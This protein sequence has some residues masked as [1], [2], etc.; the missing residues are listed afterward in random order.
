MVVHPLMLNPEMAW[1]QV[2]FVAIGS[3]KGQ[4]LNRLE[5]RLHPISTIVTFP[6]HL[7]SPTF[8]LLLQRMLSSSALI[9]V[10]SSYCSSSQQWVE[11]VGGV[12]LVQESVIF[13]DLPTYIQY[14]CKP[15]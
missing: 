2:M 8:Y 3:L 13:S 5:Q 9:L 11:S 12:C 4:S 14:T 7:Q 10:Y 6:F 15:T 1:G